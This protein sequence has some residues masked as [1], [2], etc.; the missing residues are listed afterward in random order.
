MSDASTVAAR[1]RVVQCAA[2]AASRHAAEGT[3][4][5]GTASP[6]R[7]TARPR[8]APVAL[9]VYTPGIRTERASRAVTRSLAGCRI[10]SLGVY[11]AVASQGFHS[12]G[13]PL[14][15][16]SHSGKSIAT[17]AWPASAWPATREP[18]QLAPALDEALA[19]PAEEAPA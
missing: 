6:S 2:S 15:H 4:P 14:V 18:V 19:A 12:A 11:T 7:S 10:V 17:Q 13:L 16:G 1:H 9:L 5:E 8:P 3:A